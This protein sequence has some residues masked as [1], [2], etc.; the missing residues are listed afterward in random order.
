MRQ[1]N[2]ARPL[3]FVAGGIIIMLT[4]LLALSAC[5][6]QQH[7]VPVA[8]TDMEKVASLL[9][10]MLQHKDLEKMTGEDAADLNIG[11]HNQMILYQLKPDKLSSPGNGCIIRSPFGVVIKDPVAGV[12]LLLPGKDKESRDKFSAVQSIFKGSITN[13]ITGTTLVNLNS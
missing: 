9:N 2:H 13:P 8:K 1:K 12:I 10:G 11:D 5:R 7:D 4:A 6:K 3:R